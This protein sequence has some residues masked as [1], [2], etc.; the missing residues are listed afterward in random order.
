MT[1]TVNGFARH[2]TDFAYTEIEL[3]L[4]YLRLAQVDPVESNAH[5]RDA[6]YACAEAR[7]QLLLLPAADPAKDV[8]AA[9]I[10]ELTEKI[11]DWEQSPR[12]TLR[13]RPR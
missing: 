12:F 13:A 10:D 5:L 9:D 2:A 8:L 11:R 1:S 7:R 3:G 4:E 6:L